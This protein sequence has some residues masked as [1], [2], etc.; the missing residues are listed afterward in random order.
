MSQPTTTI[1]ETNSPNQKTTDNNSESQDLVEVEEDLPKDL[2]LITAANR[3]PN[4]HLY[5]TTLCP[6]KDRP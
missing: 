6:S 2:P 1:S 4:N 5:E 3:L